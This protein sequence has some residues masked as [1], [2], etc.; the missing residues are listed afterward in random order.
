MVALHEAYT[1]QKKQT[2]HEN[3]VQ[4]WVGVVVNV[5]V[6]PG[7]VQRCAV[8]WYAGAVPVLVV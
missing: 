2:Y 7:A 5:S 3:V 4:G 1:G 8:P 6:R